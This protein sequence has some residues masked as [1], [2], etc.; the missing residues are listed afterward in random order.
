MRNHVQIALAAMLLT[1]GLANAGKA[2]AA[3]GDCYDACDAALTD[4]LVSGR[5]ANLC[6]QVYRN[7]VGRCR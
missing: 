6:F 3:I 4:C 2:L 5:P 7:C 1:L